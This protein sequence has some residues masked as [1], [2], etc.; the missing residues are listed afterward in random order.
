[1]ARRRGRSS[2]RRRSGGS[3]GFSI[4]G[5][6]KGIFSIKGLITGAVVALGIFMIPQ[7]KGQFEKAANKINPPKV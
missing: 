5:I 3:R 6:F 1:M 7:L 4:G 2:G